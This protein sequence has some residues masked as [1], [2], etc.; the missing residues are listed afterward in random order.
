MQGE[1]REVRTEMKVPDRGVVRFALEVVQEDEA[2]VDL[3]A[4]AVDHAIRIVDRSVLVAVQENHEVVRERI[5]IVLTVDLCALIVVH[6]VHIVGQAGLVVD[7]DALLVDPY[8]PIVLQGVHEVVQTDR[9]VV[10]DVLTAV[11]EDR[12]V[13]HIALVVGLG[14]LAVAL[15]DRSV[16]LDDLKAVQIGRPVVLVVLGVVPD[17][18]VNH[19]ALVV[20]Q[21]DLG[22]DPVVVVAEVGVAAAR[23]PD[24]DHDLPLLHAPGLDHVAAPDQ[25]LDRALG[26]IHD[27]L[28]LSKR[29]KEEIF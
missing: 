21:Q 4:L 5:L 24:L 28:P 14:G 13:V 27:L 9:A 7:L 22:A 8:N 15:A 12:V 1:N 19:D 18:I 23:S 20:V 25:Y 2:E 26:V 11:R 16:D 6:V 10:P 29:V 3:Y 17:H